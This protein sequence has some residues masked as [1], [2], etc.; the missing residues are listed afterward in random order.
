MKTQLLTA[1]V[2]LSLLT[3]CGGGGGDDNAPA[4]KPQSNNGKVPTGK[5]FLPETDWDKGYEAFREFSW[6]RNGQTFATSEVNKGHTID[7][8]KLPAGFSEFPAQLTSTRSNGQQITENVNVRSYNGFHAGVFTTSGIRTQLPNDDNNEFNQIFIR[9]TTQLPSAGKATYAGRAFDQN[10]VNDA[11]F[12]YTINFGTRRGSGEVAASQGVE[13]I[14]LK[15]AEIKRETGDGLTVYALDGDAHV[16][17]DRLPGGD[18][19]Y[20]FTLAGPNAEE[21]IGN[22]GYTDKKNQGGLLLMH[23]TRGEISQ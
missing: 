18:H 8:V 22:V 14:L 9:P 4:D 5:Y 1:L 13:K 16:E 17:G 3:A 11:S 21:I 20:T 6:Q 12:T 7:S 2:T 19:E 15:E 10:P 23:G